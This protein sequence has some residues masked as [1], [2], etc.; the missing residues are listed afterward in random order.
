MALEPRLT[1][2]EDIEAIRQLK[3]RYCVVC[4]GNHDPELVVTLSTA[5]GI[6]E[7]EGIGRHEGHQLVSD[8]FRSFQESISFS[9]HMVQ[10]RII[11]VDARHGALVLHGQAPAEDAQQ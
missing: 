6:W 3:A 7:G 11:E 4:A 1:R 5:D 10:T 2:L 8:L 9:L